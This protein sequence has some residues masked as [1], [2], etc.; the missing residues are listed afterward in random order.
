MRS[1]LFAFIET[2]CSP[3]SRTN[4]H[5]YNKEKMSA[6]YTTWA[7]RTTG[8]NY[9]CY[10]LRH[11][12]HTVKLLRRV[13]SNSRL[14]S[15]LTLWRPLLSYGYGYKSSW[16]DRVKPSFVIFDIRTLWRSVLSVR[17][18]GCQKLQNDGLTP[19]GTGCFIAVPIRQ[20]WASKG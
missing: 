20:Q 11:V 6:T 2:L 18:P 9:A 8:A 10:F 3:V 4:R 5:N 14:A 13:D 19:S 7:Y 17:V 15:V 12:L 1:V 16:P